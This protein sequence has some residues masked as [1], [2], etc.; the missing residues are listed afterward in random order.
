MRN[1][2]ESVSLTSILSLGDNGQVLEY[3][4]LAS[5]MMEA[6]LPYSIFEE[7]KKAE[8]AK[9]NFKITGCFPCKDNRQREQVE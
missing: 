7:S 1:V 6:A 8:A 2:L 3:G 9:S 5:R 4:A